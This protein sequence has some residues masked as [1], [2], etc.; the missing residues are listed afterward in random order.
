MKKDLISKVENLAYQMLEEFIASGQPSMNIGLESKNGKTANVV[1]VLYKTNHNED[2]HLNIF[3]YGDII[4]PSI[5]SVAWESITYGIQD[6]FIE[7]RGSV[8]YIYVRSENEL[9][10]YCDELVKQNK[11]I[12]IDERVFC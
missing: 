9:K 5:M 11:S 1:S 7:R 3:Y 8:P 4:R 2:A 12:I 10:E 6:M